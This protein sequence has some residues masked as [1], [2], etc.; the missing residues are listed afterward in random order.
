MWEPFR[1]VDVIVE[2]LDHAS[3]K[4]SL[5]EEVLLN[6]HGKPIVAASGVAGIGGSERIRQKRYE[7]LYLVEDT[8]A[9]SSEEDI[10]LSP[11]VGHF[12]HHQANLVLELL[13]GVKV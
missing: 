4:V 11:K 6:L 1:D 12:A 10:L 9:L 13:A 3:T 7:N 5:I 2:A 8:E